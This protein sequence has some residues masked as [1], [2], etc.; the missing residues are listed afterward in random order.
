MALP[1]YV[2]GRLIKITVG[3]K[4]LDN[5]QHFVNV[6]LL[7][8]GPGRFTNSFW[9]MTGSDVYATVDGLIEACAADPDY[10]PRVGVQ[11]VT[12]AKEGGE[13][14]PARLSSRLDRIWLID[15][16]GNPIPEPPA[17]RKAAAATNGK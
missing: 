9:C 17:A 16:E 3:D 11:G 6:D 7:C 13:G 14:R 12:T 2:T 15:T 8:D 1:V 10:L 5:G 4:P